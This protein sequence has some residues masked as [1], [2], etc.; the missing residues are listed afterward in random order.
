MP[1]KFKRQGPDRLRNRSTRPVHPAIAKPE[2][3]LLVRPLAVSAAFINGLP[4]YP[5]GCTSPNE[6]ES[7]STASPL[8]EVQ[9]SRVITRGFGLHWLGNSATSGYRRHIS[10]GNYVVRTGRTRLF[11]CLVLLSAN[12]IGKTVLISAKNLT[13][14]WTRSLTSHAMVPRRGEER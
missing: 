4:F 13:I 11:D 3:K 6:M 9:T 12:Q 14:A 2:K 8:T 5:V 7:Q 10:T 1:S